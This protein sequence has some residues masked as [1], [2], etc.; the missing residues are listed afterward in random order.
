MAV[1]IIVRKIAQL[2]CYEV[3]TSTVLATVGVERTDGTT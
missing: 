1:K 2:V 3:T